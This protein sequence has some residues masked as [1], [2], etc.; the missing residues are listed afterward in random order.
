MPPVKKTK[1]DIKSPRV[2][3]VNFNVERER[4]FLRYVKYL[5]SPLHIMWRNFLAGTFHGLGFILGS[6]VLLALFGFIT[7]KILINI[8]FISDFGQA[9]N[10]WLQGIL[11]TQQ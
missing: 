3:H 8:P 6:A 9:L 1:H 11:E 2:A 4:N 7:S 5:S 10:I